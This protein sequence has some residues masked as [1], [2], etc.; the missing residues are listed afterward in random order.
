MSCSLWHAMPFLLTVEIKIWKILIA[1]DYHQP[2]NQFHMSCIPF[3]LVLDSKLVYVADSTLLKIRYLIF[4][5]S[6]LLS[7]GNVSWAAACHLAW[8]HGLTCNFLVISDP[9]AAFA[10]TCTLP[11]NGWS[12]HILCTS[13]CI[14]GTV[15]SG[16]PVSHYLQFSTHFCF[17]CP[18]LSCLVY[19]TWQ[20][21]NLWPLL[22]C[23]VPSSA[24]SICPLLGPRI[25]LSHL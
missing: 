15:C 12:S 13:C 10:L 11:W 21:Q 22:C 18:S 2:P 25:V 7:F 17:L 1:L 9:T 23:P 16:C 8:Y 20:S 6:K 19:Y 14:Q 24:L 5:K 4:I 3:W